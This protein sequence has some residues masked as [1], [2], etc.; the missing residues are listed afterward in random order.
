[1][2]WWDETE[3]RALGHRGEAAWALTLWRRLVEAGC[4]AEAALWPAHG[5][6]ALYACGC[7]LVQAVDALLVAPAGS[8]RLSLL[9]LVWW[10]RRTAAAVAA[11][12]RPLLVLLD[13]L[14][15]EPD[16]LMAAVLAAGEEPVAAPPEEQPKLEGRY[17][18]RHLLYERL[19]LKMEAEGL[20]AAV[21]QP[22]C[23]DLA[24][25]YEEFLAALHTLHRLH[26]AR[27]SF[28]TLAQALTDIHATFHLVVGPRHLGWGR[29]E[30]G[31]P[32]VPG[33]LVRLMAALGPVE[34]AGPGVATSS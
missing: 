25:V 1:M 20:P 27:P 3:R 31:A 33:L 5:L 6:A 12:E 11:L 26:S 7:D 15:L 22:L 10:C 29:L 4:P 21:R 23:R 14:R 19:D 2:H 9:E 30:P 16:D 34:A 17:Q 13:C 18:R 24:T 32:V 8:L 28:R